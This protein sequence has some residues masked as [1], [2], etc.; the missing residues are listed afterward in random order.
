MKLIKQELEHYMH[1]ELCVKQHTICYRAGKGSKYW[2]LGDYKNAMLLY[3]NI[4]YSFKLMPNP[5]DVDIG[6][7]Q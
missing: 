4:I 5:Q 3:H 2:V 6:S 1:H 7:K